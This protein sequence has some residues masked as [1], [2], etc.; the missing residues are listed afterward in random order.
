MR[1]SD[2]VSEALIVDTSMTLRLH[3]IEQCSLSLIGCNLT[4][5]ETHKKKASIEAFFA[6]L[7]KYTQDA[8][9]NS[10]SP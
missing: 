7:G 6:S 1:L 10:T 8:G 9:T 2:A 3:S 5:Y 4:N